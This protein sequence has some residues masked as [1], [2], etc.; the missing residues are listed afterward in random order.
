MVKF[1]LNERHFS[2]RLGYYLNSIKYIDNV[3]LLSNCFMYVCTCNTSI[4]LF[5]LCMLMMYS[6][7]SFYVIIFLYL[8]SYTIITIN[9]YSINVMVKFG[10]CF[11][12]QNIDTNC[13]CV[14][15]LLKYLVHS[16]NQSLSFFIKKKIY[17]VLHSFFDYFF[18]I[19]FP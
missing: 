17:K 13:S 4:S 16:R 12:I 14:L 10:I 6:S 15:P 9:L 2:L 18:L 1:V 5:L 7:R 3:S 19:I 8:V 11:C